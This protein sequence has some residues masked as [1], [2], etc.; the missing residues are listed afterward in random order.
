MGAK[1]AIFLVVTELS[2]IVYGGWNKEK[3]REDIL[4]EVQD[5]H[6]DATQFVA[7]TAHIH[8]L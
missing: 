1:T 7:V 3:E 4:Y 2:P 8:S 6:L 5:I